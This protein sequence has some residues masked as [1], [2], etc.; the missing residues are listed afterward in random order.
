MCWL[1]M[2]S[3]YFL[4]MW[5]EV[6]RLER[7]R[8]PC[9]LRNT[10][11]FPLPGTDRTAGVKRPAECLLEDRREPLQTVA[12]QTELSEAGLEAGEAE[13]EALV[14]RV[15][16]QVQ[17]QQAR[18]VSEDVGL[19]V[20]EEVVGELEVGQVGE[21][22]QGGGEA[23]QEVVGQVEV[24]EAGGERGQAGAGQGEQL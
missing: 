23:G 17:A 7:P 6:A 9:R 21:G 2:S 19:Q 16:G 13:V 3:R 8:L 12:G 15:V 1:V 11:Y 20:G 10:Q 14:E 18:E 4:R 5:V 24:G 22:G